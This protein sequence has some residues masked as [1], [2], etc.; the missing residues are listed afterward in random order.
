MPVMRSY[1]DAT[2]VELLQEQSAQP[3]ATK[4]SKEDEQARSYVVAWRDK[5]RYE[6]IEKVNIWRSP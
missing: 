2:P 3:S 6:R 5:L 1:G 4:L